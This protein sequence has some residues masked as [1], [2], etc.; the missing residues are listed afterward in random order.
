MVGTSNNTR[1][2]IAASHT[3]EQRFEDD[4]NVTESNNT[5][6][7]GMQAFGD[8]ARNATMITHMANI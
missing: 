4:M 6:G 2:Q 8:E 7:M 5:M 3:P 1:D